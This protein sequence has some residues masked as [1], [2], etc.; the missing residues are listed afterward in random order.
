MIQTEIKV[1]TTLGSG[2]VKTAVGTCELYSSIAEVKESLTEAHF[3]LL[4][5]AI[6]IRSQD[7]L[8][9]TLKEAD[10]SKAMLKAL[11]ARMKE[12]PAEF[13]EKLKALGLEHPR[14]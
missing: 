11:R 3:E 1:K 9:N 14:K 12:N 5:S 4:N 13:T 7:K 6:I 10:E 2:E 8:R